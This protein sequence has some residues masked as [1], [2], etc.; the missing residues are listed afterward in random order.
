MP[1]QTATST[2]TPTAMAGTSKRGLDSLVAGADL[3]GAFMSTGSLGTGGASAG[4]PG[5]NWA[6]SSE[7]VGRPA[8]LGLKQRRTAPVSGSEDSPRPAAGFCVSASTRVMP[9]PQTS[10]AASIAPFFAS[11]GSYTEGFAVTMAGSPA[12]RMVSLASL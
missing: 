1:A 10:P 12:D 3:P 9:R 4:D 2:M 8:G 7:I 11:G 6:W 5:L